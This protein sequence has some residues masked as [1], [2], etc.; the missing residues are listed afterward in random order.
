MR[1][2]VLN[3]LHRVSIAGALL[4]LLPGAAAAQELAGTWETDVRGADRNGRVQL[5]LA[6][7]HGDRG[8][9]RSGFRVQVAELAGVSLEQ[10]SGRADDV[11]FELSR[12]AGVVGFEGDVR[13]GH[14]SGTFR[15]VASPAFVASM[16]ERGF[17]GITADRLFLM[18][19][20]DVTVA[21]VDGLRELG[22]R[23]LSEEELVRFAIHGVSPQ[24][25][26]DLN[27]LGYDSI[28]PDQLVRLRIHGVTPE[29]IRA[30]RTA[31]G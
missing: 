16:A 3:S 2:S 8:T 22:Y 25:I 15:F 9:T 14:G 7:Q 12:E 19:T 23:S 24:L 30:V 21:Y 20:Q 5:N 17:A 28:G 31:L 18:A 29:Y 13:D 1:C 11:A 6:V 10:L 26:R 4:L 27:A